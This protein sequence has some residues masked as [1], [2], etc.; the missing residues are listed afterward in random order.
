MLQSTMKQPIL[1]KAVPFRSDQIIIRR[2]GNAHT[3]W[4][5][6]S[7][8]FI[9]L[10]EPAFEVYRLFSEG[11]KIRE[12]KEICQAK[13]GHLE[14]DIHRFVDEIIGY[15]RFYNN[16]KNASQVSKIGQLKTVPHCGHFITEVNYRFGS[17]NIAIRYQNEYLK[18][19]V[20]PL[21]S[22][23]EVAKDSAPEIILECFEHDRLLILISNGE[24]VAAFRTK[25][26]EFYKGAISQQIYS[27]IYQRSFND[28]MMMLHASGIIKNQQAV[29]FSAAAGS[30]KSTISALLKAQGYE[31]LSDDF[32]ATDE[33]GKVYPFPAAITVKEG[34]VST[35]SE[36]YPELNNTKPQEAFTGKMVRY[37]AVNN[38]NA[39]SAQG[40]PVK[41]FVFVNYSTEEPFA[42]EKVEPKE[43]LRLLLKETWVKPTAK[44]VNRFFDWLQQTAFYRLRY[45]N[46]DEATE[47]VEKLYRL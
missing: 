15:I 1:N 40:F 2:I 32:I 11:I 33:A 38:L 19:A 47:A 45:S 14:T 27:L 6:H 24:L 10:E 44:N 21:I 4:F 8:S 12:I 13:Y 17:A 41:A 23:L 36:F 35:L 37:I 29:L 26:F 22:H 25:D 42:L 7:K 39:A 18:F 30:G 5:D 9:L 31:F 46:T 43:A 28:W 20:H 16:P 3:L 34:A